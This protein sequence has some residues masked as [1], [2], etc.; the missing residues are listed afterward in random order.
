[1]G[2]RADKIGPFCK[3]FVLG[4]L[5]RVYSALF[6]LPTTSKAP[7]NYALQPI[8]AF[9]LEGMESVLDLESVD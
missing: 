9:V 1:M 2:C 7:T 3:S 4:L 8:F 6:S 5:Q